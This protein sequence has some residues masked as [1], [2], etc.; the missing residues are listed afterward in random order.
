MSNLGNSIR[1]SAY[2]ALM[3]AALLTAGCGG[4][5]TGG[6]QLPAKLP[7]LAGTP[8]PTQ[9]I[10]S[11]AGTTTAAT[12]VVKVVVDSSGAV[13]S[14]SVVQS[15]QNTVIDA[16]AL[17]LV[18]QSKFVPGLAGCGNNPAPNSTTVSVS[19]SPNA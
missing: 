5:S 11:G 1:L 9:P 13:T 18:Q 19:F 17:S 14:A 4:A 15:S 2:G 8:I 16:S 3:F 6:C 12:V 7:S 10:P